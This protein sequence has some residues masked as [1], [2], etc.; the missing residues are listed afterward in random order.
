MSGI[1]VTYSG[2]VAFGATVF[3]MFLGLV[4]ML[5]ITRTLSPDEFGVF[6]LLISMIGYFL[7]SEAIIS[8]WAIRQIARG[9]DVGK[10]SVLSSIGVSSAS[11]PLFVVYVSLI[12]QNN[13]TLEIITLG[14][15]LVVAQFVSQTLTGIN[16]GYKPHMT[17]Y[18]ILLFSI[19]KVAVGA[20]TILLLQWEILGA[21]LAILV[22]YLG[23]IVFQTCVAFPRLKGTIRLSV[24]LAWIRTSWLPLFAGMSRYLYMLDVVLY[25]IITGSVVGVAYY[26]AA[27]TIARITTHS[28]LVAQAL[29]P[30]L[31][32]DEAYVGIDGSFRLV[33]Y[34]AIPTTVLSIIFAEAG[35]FVLNPLYQDA[36]P[37]VVLLA[38]RGFFFAIRGVPRTILTGTER[39]DM[40]GH[41]SFSRLVGS[42]LFKT[43]LV[44]TIFNLLYIVLLVLCLILL[45][46][47]ELQ[48]IIA[49]AAIGLLIEAASAIFMWKYAD[50]VISLPVPWMSMFKFS[51]AAATFVVVFYA[52]SPH[53]LDYSLGIYGF[54]PLAAAQ[55]V[56]C[57]A[58]YL[59]VT[60]MIDHNT[61][62]LLKSAYNMVRRRRTQ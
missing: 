59:G 17:G 24:L 39:V 21:I 31:I 10:T 38:I 28:R 18:S 61:R 40:D 29:Y 7:V 6:S 3:G 50:K 1:R 62:H 35:L 37:V 27:F 22:S 23:K 26:Y 20:F 49:W 15:I 16:S 53:I 54:L 32:A 33:L 46:G 43:P 44:L 2:I 48:L 4:F 30:K 45:E 11:I 36:W 12:L 34:I 56:I 51:L 9:E 47:S 41:V 14:G 52:T 19:L 5:M 60:Y 42:H 58:V 57:S 25:S 8:Y 13:V 55:V